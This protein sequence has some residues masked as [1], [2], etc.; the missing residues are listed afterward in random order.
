MDI[1]II[2]NQAELTSPFFASA[3]EY[4]QFRERYIAD[5]APKLEK[6]KQAQLA[7]WHEAQTRIVA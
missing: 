3:K 2:P 4:E 7:S 6:A 5:V 1:E